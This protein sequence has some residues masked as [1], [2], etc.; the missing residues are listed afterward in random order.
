MAAMRGEQGNACGKPGKGSVRAEELDGIF[1][2]GFQGANDVF[3]PPQASGY[4]VSAI[5]NGS[6]GLVCPS[7][8]N[9]SFADAWQQM[10]RS[11]PAEQ[12]GQAWQWGLAWGGRLGADTGALFAGADAAAQLEDLSRERPGVVQMEWTS[13]RCGGGACPTARDE[14]YSFRVHA[15]ELEGADGEALAERVPVEGEPCGIFDSGTPFTYF[16]ETFVDPLAE[17]V[18]SLAP[19]RSAAIVVRTDGAPFVFNVT[20]KTVEL[21]ERNLFALPVPVSSLK[22][23]SGCFFGLPT[24]IWYE[25]FHFNF[26][27]NSSGGVFTPSDRST[28]SFVPRREA[29]YDSL[30][31]FQ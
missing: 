30:S 16:P 27:V 25:Y 24:L 21:V 5:F 18:E 20:K 3:C 23:R 17:Y 13:R 22:G 4:D 19:G 9:Q 7:G 29:L 11:Q 1:G 14:M 8:C 31:A 2:F 15:Y 12:P 26:A 10:L 6:E 28:L